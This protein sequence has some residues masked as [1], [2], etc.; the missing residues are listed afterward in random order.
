MSLGY[1]ES[2]LFITSRAIGLSLS[3]AEVLSPQ[4]EKNRCAYGLGDGSVV[5]QEVLRVVREFT[6]E[7]IQVKME[8][9][10][11]CPMNVVEMFF[12]IRL[13]SF[14]VQR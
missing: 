3:E 10:A 12:S 8:T 7:P 2:P 9:D 6:G 4:T 5:Q 1:T 14:L 13:C 11:P